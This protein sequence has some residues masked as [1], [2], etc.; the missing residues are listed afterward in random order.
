MRFGLIR[1]DFATQER[2]WKQSAYWYRDVACG[3]GID[4]PVRAPEEQLPGVS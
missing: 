3:N 4:A 2:T 1:T